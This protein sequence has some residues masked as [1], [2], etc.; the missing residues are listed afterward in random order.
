MTV[1][2]PEPIPEKGFAIKD[3]ALTAIATGRRAQ[4]LRELRHILQEIHPGSIYY[5][6]WGGLLRPRYYDREYKNDFANW[7][8]TSL[9]HQTLAERLSVIDPNDYADIE[10]LR[11]EL[12]D[13]IDDVLDATEQVPWAVADEQFHFMRS[14]IVVFSTHHLV[15]EPEQLKEVVPAMTISSVFYHF[16]DARSR[17]DAHVDDFRAWLGGM[18]PRYDDLCERLAQVDP[19][20]ESLPRLRDQ[21]SELLNAYFGGDAS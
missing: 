13:T 2:Q 5:H 12:L 18:S 21:L 14:Q 1:N 6:F 8:A 4:N 10:R 20:F 17:T 16:I 3:C 11:E 7:A 9:H 15:A 19:Y